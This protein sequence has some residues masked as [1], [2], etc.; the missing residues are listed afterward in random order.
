MPA[1]SLTSVRKSYGSG[2]PAVD[3]LDL[4]I[5]DGSFTCLLGPSGCGKT[6]TL[7]MISGLE[8][9]NAGT[10]TVGGR[11]MDS[12]RQGVFVPPEKRGMGLVFQNYA[13]WPHLTVAKNVE[14]GLRVRKVKP[15]QRAERAAAA[16]KMMQIDWAADRY[17][18][19]LSGGQQQRVSLARMLAVSPDVLLLDEP[20]SNLD[21]QLRLDMRAEL[22]R[23]HDET[24]HTIVFVTHDQLEAMTM[25]THVVV[26]NKGV[27]QQMAPP[28]EVYGR[29]ADTFVA[30]FV[31]SPPMNLF[32]AG[33]DA[34]RDTFTGAAR[35]RVL[36]ARPDLTERLATVGVR[37]ENLRLLHDAEEPPADA[38][39]FEG[40]VKTA[41]PT[42]SS[43]TVLVTAGRTELYLVSYTDVRATPATTVRCAVRTA[44]LH[45][46]DPSGTRLPDEAVGAVPMKED[47]ATWAS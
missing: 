12:T 47:T 6:T 29:P 13:L 33:D 26:M 8:S 17:P 34:A 31:G 40:T 11:V 39:V 43:W 41:L 3:N 16:L 28:M 36:A 10:I 4:E 46:F 20:L 1:I 19:Q 38:F 44:D 2:P 37:P 9:L 21:A 24:G 27:V 23:I 15:A 42:G 7:R 30:R 18:A 22:K 25:A 14:F 32:E 35:E 5:P 45:L